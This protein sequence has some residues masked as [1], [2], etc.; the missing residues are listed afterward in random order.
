M[1]PNIHN[2]IIERL[3]YE[4]FNEVDLNGI[5][6]F[7]GDDP[8]LAEEISLFMDIDKALNE[9]DIMS[10]RNQLKNITNHTTDASATG[11]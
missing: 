9:E 6:A 10:L 5:Q 1:I 7:A 11:H 4:G 2:K 3:E 8:L